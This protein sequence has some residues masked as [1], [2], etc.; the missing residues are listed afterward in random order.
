M[1]EDNRR[2][3]NESVDKKPLV[4]VVIPVYNVSRYLQQCLD[5]VV[6]QTYRNLEIII[7]D[8]GST[9]GSG[10]ICDRYEKR[11]ERSHVIHSA[12]RGLSSAR[13]LGLDKIRG[14]YILFVNSDDWIEP[15]TVDTLIRAAMQTGADIVIA[16]SVPSI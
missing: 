8:D 11:D 7:V 4:F 10:R 12:N 3:S 15:H 1:S 14:S 9:D 16:K 2:A 13:N 6:S 5:S